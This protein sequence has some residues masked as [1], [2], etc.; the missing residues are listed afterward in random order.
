[1][2]QLRHQAQYPLGPSPFILLIRV[3]RF[4]HSDDPRAISGCAISPTYPSLLP[5]HSVNDASQG[6]GDCGQ[7]LDLSYDRICIVCRSAREAKIRV[8]AIVAV[9]VRT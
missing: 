9:C 1:M 8:F 5:K 6:E 7:C 2:V 4:F 3:H